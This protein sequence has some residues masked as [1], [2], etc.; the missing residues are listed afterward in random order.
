LSKSNEILTAKAYSN[1]VQTAN[2]V[3]IVQGM[4]P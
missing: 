1:G 3:K 4:R 2:F